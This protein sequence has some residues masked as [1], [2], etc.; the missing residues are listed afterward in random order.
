MD[1]SPSEITL[2]HYLKRKFHSGQE[3]YFHKLNKW[4]QHSE[5][6]NKPLILKAKPGTG[7]KTI[8]SHWHN[9]IS[10]SNANKVNLLLTQKE[11]NL[12]IIHYASNGSNNQNYFYCLYRIIIKLKEALK[13]KQNVDLLEQKIRKYFAYWLD[14]SNSQV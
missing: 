6:S 3:Q 8:F 1:F 10:M 11:K 9:Q 4:L 13:L 14:I 5:E 12:S 7:I 2:Q